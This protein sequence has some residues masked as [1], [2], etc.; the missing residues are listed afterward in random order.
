MKWQHSGRSRKDYA[1]QARFLTDNLQ[2]PSLHARKYD[3]SQDLWQA[4]VTMGWRFYFKIE[5]GTVAIIR[6]V[7]HPE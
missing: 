2:H 3:E 5:S 1:K 4:R 6:I 7:P